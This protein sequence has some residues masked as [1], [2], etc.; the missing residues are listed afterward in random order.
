MP[1]IAATIEHDE[2][3][4]DPR[5]HES[6]H[7]GTEKNSVSRSEEARM[8]ESTRRR[9]K[10]F[11]EEDPDLENSNEVSASP[12]RQPLA[13]L[14]I[15]SLIVFVFHVLFGA[16]TIVVMHLANNNEDVQQLNVRFWLTYF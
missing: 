8:G 11:D 4:D 13:P 2:E 16:A 14:H 12:G 1:D 5:I 9:T 10:S 7:R 3:V 15:C 6:A